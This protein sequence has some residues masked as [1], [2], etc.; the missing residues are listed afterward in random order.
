MGERVRKRERREICERE[1]V[2]YSV[3]KMRE[4]SEKL[5]VHGIA[6]RRKERERVREIDRKRVKSECTQD[7]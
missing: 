1:N 5:I 3:H 4:S 2:R 7:R 6:E